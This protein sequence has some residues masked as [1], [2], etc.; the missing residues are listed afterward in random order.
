LVNRVVAHGGRV[1]YKHNPDGSRSP[2]ELNIN[3]FDALS[4]PNGHE[5]IDTQIDRFVVAH[6]IMLALSGMP[7]IYF[8]SLFG[9]RGWSEGVALTG[10]NRAINR[11]KFD[12]AEVERELRDPQSRRARVFNRLKSLLE[13]RASSAA[14]APQSPQRV[15]QF[16][17]GVMAVLRGSGDEQVLCLHN[18]AAQAQA[19][20]LER[21]WAAASDLLTGDGAAATAAAVEEGAVTLAPYQVVWLRQND[22]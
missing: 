1:S 19:I 20:R 16:R 5:S 11:Q 15:L 17:S 2:Y 22:R 4:D 8:H 21:E 7:G 13:A 9:S 10:Q 6:A 18:V 3:Y 12:R 14:F